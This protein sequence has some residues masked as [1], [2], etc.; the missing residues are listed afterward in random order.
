[1]DS[2]LGHEMGPGSP[3]QGETEGGDDPHHAQVKGR[4]QAL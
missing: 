1:M 2:R 3:S 4:G